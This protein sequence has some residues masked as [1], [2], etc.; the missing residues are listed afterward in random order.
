MIFS[1]YIYIYSGAPKPPTE[2]YKNVFK[3]QETPGNNC[4]VCRENDRLI[5]TKRQCKKAYN[6]A[7]GEAV[8]FDK[9]EVGNW[10]NHPPGCH[11][12]MIDMKM[13]RY[14][15]TRNNKNNGRYIN[16]NNYG[17]NNGD[18]LKICN[19]KVYL[20]LYIYIYI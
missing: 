20:I 10:A 3:L 14:F 19:Q 6:E 9:E 13:I 4:P 1:I 11:V 12:A 5:N 18:F 17:R 7:I 15:N 16:F 8:P 2:K